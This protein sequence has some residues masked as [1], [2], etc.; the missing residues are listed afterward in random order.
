VSDSASDEI[1]AE[2]PHGVADHGDA[3]GHEHDDHVH[4]DEPLGPIDWPA[5]GAGALGLL[6]GLVIAVALAIA[7]GAV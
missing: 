2:G 6:I 7:V 1:I 3:P 5:Y 4:A